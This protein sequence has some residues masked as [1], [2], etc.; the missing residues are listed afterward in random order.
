[1]RRS[2]A[3]LARLKDP[4]IVVHCGTGH[5]ARSIQPSTDH[6]KAQVVEKLELRFPTVEDHLLRSIGGS[7]PPMLLP[8]PGY[9]RIREFRWSHPLL[10]GH[11]PARPLESPSP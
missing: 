11:R 2:T 10:A 3:L 7:F 8:L 1:N 5:H 4:A 6:H 9:F